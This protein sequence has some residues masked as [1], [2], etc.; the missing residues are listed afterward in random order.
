MK[1]YTKTGDKGTTS[2]YGGVKISKAAIRLD[3]YGTTDELNSFVGNIIA[4]STHE[5]II[6]QLVEIQKELFVVGSE[7]ATPKEK[8]YLANGQARI[9]NIVYD[10]DIE[11][12]E[13]WIDDWENELEPL[14]SFIL[15][16]G[17]KASAAA[18][19]AR[20]VC[21]RAERCVVGLAA[22]EEIREILP[23][24]LNRLSDYFFVLARVLSKLNGE[25]EVKWQP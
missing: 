9:A 5:K 8:M 2:L 20:T 16:G 13:K 11:K 18:H 7:L 3:A 25:E 6:F 14:K 21:R 4:F 19:I 17:G 10:S 24:Y 22:Q 12:L 15:P 23:K 1:I